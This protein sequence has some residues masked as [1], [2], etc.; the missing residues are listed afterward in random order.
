M[1]TRI[2]RRIG[3]RQQAKAFIRGP[4]QSFRPLLLDWYT[5]EVGR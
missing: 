3:R 1:S 5:K 4:F 2:R